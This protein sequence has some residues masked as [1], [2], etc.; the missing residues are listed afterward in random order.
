MKIQKKIAAN[1]DTAELN[2]IV[3]EDACNFVKQAIDSLGAFARRT[4]DSFAKDCIANLSV[5]LLD[6]KSHK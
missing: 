5:V 2:S 4:G 1:D 6:M 3:Y